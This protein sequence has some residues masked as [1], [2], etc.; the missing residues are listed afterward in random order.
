MTERERLRVPYLGWQ[1][2][3]LRL[4]RGLTQ[5][6][7]GAAIGYSTAYISDIERGRQMPSG[8]FLACMATFFRVQLVLKPQEDDE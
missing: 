7:L 8:K 5:G 4:A 2:K 6:Q 3:H 1:I